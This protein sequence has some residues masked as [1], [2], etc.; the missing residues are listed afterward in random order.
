MPY[1]L[2][3]TE[4]K[5]GRLNGR[6]QRIR[7]VNANLRLRTVQLLDLRWVGNWSRGWSPVSPIPKP[8]RAVILGSF[9]WLVLVKK[10]VKGNMP[11]SLG[12]RWTRIT[13]VPIQP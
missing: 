12:R 13:L 3:R 5:K 11:P 2:E 7:E 9:M 10:G 8:V 6:V 4:K 1:D